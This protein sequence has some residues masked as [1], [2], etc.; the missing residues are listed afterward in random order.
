LTEDCVLETVRQLEMEYGGS[1]HDNR[2]SI[3]SFQYPR[4]SGMASIERGYG[5]QV[6]GSLAI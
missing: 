1:D 4:A 3:P 2:M 6:S 5:V